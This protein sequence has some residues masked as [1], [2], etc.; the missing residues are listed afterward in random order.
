MQAPLGLEDAL[1]LIN[2]ALRARAKPPQQ[3]LDE[4]SAILSE[5]VFS[6]AGA[7]SDAELAQT[8]LDAVGRGVATAWAACA[9]VELLVDGSVPAGWGWELGDADG[10]ERSFFGALEAGSKVTLL[11]AGLDG[12]EVSLAVS[13]LEIAYSW[14]L[15]AEPLTLELP[16]GAIL[17]QL[18]A[19]AAPA[20]GP[21]AASDL[22]SQSP[23][24]PACACPE[25]HPYCWA[26]DGQCYASILGAEPAESCTGACTAGFAS[27]RL[28]QTA[29]AVASDLAGTAREVVT[30]VIGAD[31][32]G[33]LLRAEADWRQV[34]HL[35]AGALSLPALTQF[36]SAAPGW[37]AGVALDYERGVL[38][39]SANL[40]I[41]GDKI[42]A[43][44]EAVVDEVLGGKYTSRHIQPDGSWRW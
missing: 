28:Q 12:A 5:M 24:A 6:P 21:A 3:V 27:P 34:A 11:L 13:R 43:L 17:H 1:H 41:D 36:V 10:L 23:S 35:L 31:A 26:A 4:I 2:P 39:A 44:E 7:E 16:I 33:V 8:L 32:R 40:T 22:A 30:L 19:A 42:L 37:P 15:P 38:W 9:E 18:G 25:T 14:R 29:E 20:V